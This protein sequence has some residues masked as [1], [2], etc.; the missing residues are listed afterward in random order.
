MLV[1]QANVYAAP[2][3]ALEG[4]RRPL[5]GL[6]LPTVVGEAG[7]PPRFL[8]TLVPSFEEVQSALGELPRCDCEPDGFF[9]VTGHTTDGPTPEGTFWR[10]NGHMHEFQADGALEPHMHRVELSGECPVESLD[11]VLRTLGWPQDELVFELVQEG[12]TLREGDFRRW[13]AA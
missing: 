7:G 10:L 12:V 1:L 13:A 8:N 2:A 5:R 6:D 3:T 11:A 4:P 9:L